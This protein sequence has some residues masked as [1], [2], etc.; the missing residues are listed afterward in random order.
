[1]LIVLEQKHQLQLN[2][3]MYNDDVFSLTI[4]ASAL[5]FCEAVITDNPKCLLVVSKPC[6]IFEYLIN[7]LSSAKSSIIKRQLYNLFILFFF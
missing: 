3:K 7:V 2:L 1:M 6:K 5:Y 4:G